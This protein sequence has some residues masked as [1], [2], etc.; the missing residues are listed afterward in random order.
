MTFPGGVHCHISASAV[1]KKGFERMR[2]R[3]EK[4]SIRAPL[5][6]ALNRVTLQQGLLGRSVFKGPGGAFN[7]FVTE[8]D[9]V[10]REIREGRTESTM[11]PLQ[12]TYDV[13][14]ILDTIRNQ[15]GLEFPDLE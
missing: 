15:I 4:G 5:Y 3:G 6:H 14:R 11:V 13:M 8:F 1:D 10:A 7:S 9:T 2:I 12:A